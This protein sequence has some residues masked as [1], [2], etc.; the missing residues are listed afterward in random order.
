MYGRPATAARM[1][2]TIDAVDPRA[3]CRPFRP[4]RTH[5]R[6]VDESLHGGVDQGVGVGRPA[7]R[8]QRRGWADRRAASGQTGC[9]LEAASVLGGSRVGGKGAPRKRAVR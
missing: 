7:R 9:L 8:G 1:L 5:T 6:V 3:A 4:R 2:G